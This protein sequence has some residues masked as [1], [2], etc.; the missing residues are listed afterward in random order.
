[1]LELLRHTLLNRNISLKVVGTFSWKPET[2]R[3]QG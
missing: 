2:A 1:V 3:Y